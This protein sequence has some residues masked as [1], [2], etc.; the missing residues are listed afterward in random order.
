MANL[1]RPNG[2]KP[3]API[4]EKRKYTVAASQTIA[5]GDLVELYTDGYVIIATA[6]SAKILGAA[7]TPVTSSSAGDAIWVYD[8]PN[9]VYVAQIATGALI[10]KYTTSD[11]ANAFDIVA[12]TGGMYINHSATGYD[13]IQVLTPAT[14]PDTGAESAVGAYMKVYCKI[15]MCNHR[16][17]SG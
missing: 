14:E 4:Y 2:F 13:I 8:N 1:N 5:V 6:T 16:L 11:T 15:S 7:A 10:D 3:A 9:Q 17:G 12:T